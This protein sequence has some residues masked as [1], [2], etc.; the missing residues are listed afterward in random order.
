MTKQFHS[1]QFDNLTIWQ[2]DIHSTETLLLTI[3]QK[4]RKCCFGYSNFLI[5]LKCRIF[6]PHVKSLK[7]SS[8]VPGQSCIEWHELSDKWESDT[9]SSHL[10]IISVA[11]PPE[12]IKGWAQQLWQLKEAEERIE[13]GLE[14]SRLSANV[15]Q[16]ILCWGELEGTFA[17]VS[18]FPVHIVLPCTHIAC[19]YCTRRGYVWHTVCAQIDKECLSPHTRPGLAP[20]KFCSP[21]KILILHYPQPGPGFGQNWPSTYHRLYL[22]ILLYLLAHTTLDTFWYAK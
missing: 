6:F 16:H 19:I 8:C 9:I 12:K 4:M 7:F 10:P 11:P 2:F 1:W 15:W 17:T 5:L 3:Q 18:T 20:N 13:S 21:Y 22:C 14:R